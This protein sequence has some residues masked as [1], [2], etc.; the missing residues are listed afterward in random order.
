[1][2][3]KLLGDLEFLTGLEVTLV[4]CDSQSRSL[5]LG[6]QPEVTPEVAV[7]STEPT[8]VFPNRLY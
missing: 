4:T 8:M 1:M 6:G 3:Q 5:P 2:V 7:G